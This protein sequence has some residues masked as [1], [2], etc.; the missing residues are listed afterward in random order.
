MP[1]T[2]NEILACS[3]EL[4]NQCIPPYSSL[5]KV[6]EI[7]SYCFNT[8]IGWC[9]IKPKPCYT[10]DI[11]PTSTTPRRNSWPLSFV[12]AACSQRE[13]AFLSFINTS[14]KKCKQKTPKWNLSALVL[15]VPQIHL[16]LCYSLEKWKSFLLVSL[17]F[18]RETTCNQH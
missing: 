17:Q 1:S 3:A 16:F 11:S 18:L 14:E 7:Q 5:K 13:N 9:F 15:N 2:A 10:L 8:L 4:I 6:R 12:I